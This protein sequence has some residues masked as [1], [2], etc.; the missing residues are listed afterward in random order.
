MRPAGSG[1]RI[2]STR[3]ELRLAVSA[4]LAEPGDQHERPVEV[5]ADPDRVRGTW[6]P[7]RPCVRDRRSR[8]RRA[9]PVA[10]GAANCGQPRA[11]PA[12]PTGPGL[13]FDSALMPAKTIDRRGTGSRPRSSRGAPR[14]A[15][16]RPRLARPRRAVAIEAHLREVRPATAPAARARRRRDARAA[17]RAARARRARSARARPP[18]RACAARAADRAARPTRASR[19]ARPS[20]P[21]ATRRGSTT[22]TAPKSRSIGKSLTSSATK[23][24]IAATPDA[25]DRRARALVRARQRGDRLQP[26]RA[27]G[28]VAGA[29]G[30]RANSRRD[31]DHE[32]AE[33]GR[34]RVER[35]LQHEQDAATTSRSRARSGRAARPRASSRR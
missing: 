9:I 26:G 3:V 12:R 25:S 5:V 10:D 6:H 32:R 17:R 1:R 8:R 15:P 7:C 4:A 34:H 21:A 28:A 23:P 29:T 2:R 33:R 13:S 20:R 14:G 16:A 18:R 19:A 11:R 35:D 31:R 30:S 22:V 27:L 24:A